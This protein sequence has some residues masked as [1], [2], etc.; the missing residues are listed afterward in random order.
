MLAAAVAAELAA[1]VMRASADDWAAAEDACA[2]VPL[3]L[4]PPPKAASV[5]RPGWVVGALKKSDGALL[6]LSRLP[7]R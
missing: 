1:M 7:L 4:L 6:P 5:W 2:C 3:P